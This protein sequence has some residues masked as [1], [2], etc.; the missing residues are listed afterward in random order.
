MTV[1]GEDVFGYWVDHSALDQV[2]RV[3]CQVCA[4]SLCFLPHQI[5]IKRVTQ[6]VPTQREQT[7]DPLKQA[8]GLVMPSMQNKIILRVNFLSW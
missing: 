8:I 6:R 3:R 7:M 4:S 5:R 1:I 2:T